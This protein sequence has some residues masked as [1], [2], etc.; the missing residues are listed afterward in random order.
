MTPEER[1]RFLEARD[2]RYRRGGFKRLGAATTAMASLVALATGGF[3]LLGQ[4]HHRGVL[5]PALPEA[6][7]LGDCFYMTVITVSTVGYGETLPLPAGM[8][9]EA[10]GD[11]RIYTGFVILFA[12]LLV[13]YSVSSATAFLVEGDLLEFWQ[14]RRSMKDARRMEKHFIVCGGGV[15]GEVVLRELV[16]THHRVVVVELDARRAEA[17]RERWQVPVLV[18]DATSD[19]VLDAAGLDRASGLAAALPND[20]DNVFLI[21]TARRRKKDLRIV[22]LAA[23]EDVRD[24]LLAAGADSVVA[25][26]SIGGMRLASELFRPTVVSFLDVML[27]GRDDS[28]RFSQITLGAEWKGRTAGDVD[29]PG[30]FGLPLLAI[31]DPKT[32]AMVFNPPRDAVLP[33]H[34]VIVTMGETSRV[35]DAERAFSPRR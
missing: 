26:S 24:K 5:S 31:E 17:V 12:L 28:V 7:S 10:F 33:D 19:D 14:R 22:S 21:V 20:R 29:L 9:F 8:T 11:V 4:L 3:F 30:R 34:A 35:E 13:G 18:G 2:R 15:T 27:R 23:S 6:W 25:A 16:E 32:R 1:R